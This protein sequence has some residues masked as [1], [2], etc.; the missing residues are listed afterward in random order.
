M[1]GAVPL[2]VRLVGLHKQFGAV[3]AVDG[4]DLEIQA[5]EFFTLLGPSGSGKTTILRLIAGF[6][7]PNAGEVLIGEHDVSPV[8]P[9][10]RNVG[11]VFQHY[12]LFP[13]MTAA[14]NVGYPLRMRRV[15]KRERLTKVER[16]LSLV[17][18]EGLGDKR[19]DELSG[20]E[21]Q[22]VA[23]ARA[24]VFAP[25]V[26]LMDEPLGALD[27]S[28]RL[29][30]GQELREIH[31]ETGVT[32]VYVTHDQEEAL[33]LS[34]RIAVLREGRLLQAGTPSE[35]FESPRNSFVARFLGE[36]NLFPVKAFEDSSWLLGD[37]LAPES[38]VLML[39]A[40]QIH[41]GEPAAGAEV[42]DARV[43]EASYLGGRTRLHC[44]TKTLRAVVVETDAPRSE[45]PCRG[46]RVSLWFDRAD[47]TLL[48]DEP[49][50]VGADLPGSEAP[51][52][53]P[54]AVPDPLE[55]FS[56]SVETG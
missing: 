27:R 41:L 8:A 53:E 38:A 49:G 10:Q 48:P 30:L 17:R 39:R 25:R 13:H 28:L 3:R 36:C 32:V 37:G 12:A 56:P 55:P 45:T 33:L 34:D 44:T 4:L 29:Q 19:P 43:E 26:L 24:L 23:L 2:P 47:A 31:R 1:S 14:G 35:L 6:E 15:S 52:L 11:V 16:A 5:G 22:R 21:Q 50:D 46:D 42:L 40:G 51:S 20:G 18:L 7:Q 9:A 54:Q